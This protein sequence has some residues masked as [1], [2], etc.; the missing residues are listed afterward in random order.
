MPCSGMSDELGGI[1]ELEVMHWADPG[2]T[3]QKEFVTRLALRQVDRR[4]VGLREVARN[5]S[6][7]RLLREFWH[8]LSAMTW[9]TESHISRASAPVRAA[10]HSRRRSG[11]RAKLP[12][13]CEFGRVTVVGRT[14]LQAIVQAVFRRRKLDGIRVPV[15]ELRCELRRHHGSRFYDSTGEHH[16]YPIAHLM[17]AIE[18]VRYQNQRKLS[19]GLL[20]QEQC[21]HSLLQH[22]I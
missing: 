9:T 14:T 22:H 1:R 18:I 5:R 15:P 7:G 13:R 8:G 12:G 4:S 19:H 16:C 17:N 2:L 10:L 20:V 21:K 3:T 6:V 11:R